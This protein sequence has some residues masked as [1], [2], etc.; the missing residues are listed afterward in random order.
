[1]VSA[2][3]SSC[4]VSGSPELSL[5]VS[6]HC[7]QPPRWSHVKPTDATAQAGFY[8]RHYWNEDRSLIKSIVSLPSVLQVLLID[9]PLQLGHNRVVAGCHPSGSVLVHR[10][11]VYVIRPLASK[12]LIDTHQFTISWCSSTMT[13]SVKWT[14]PGTSA[15]SSPSRSTPVHTFLATSTRTSNVSLHLGGR[16]S[17]LAL[18]RV[19]SLGSNDRQRESCSSIT[20]YAQADL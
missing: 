7:P 6:R 14:Y 9:L 18:I 20:C 1:M 8:L 15:S 17:S 10:C 5:A 4:L 12:R 2:S 16:W 13:S 3:G 11:V 19:I